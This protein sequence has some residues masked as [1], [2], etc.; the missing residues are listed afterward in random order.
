MLTNNHTYT[1][2]VVDDNDIDR[3]RTILYLRTIP[4]LKLTGE[5]RSAEEALASPVLSSVDVL[6]L[7]VDMPGLSGLELRRQ[8]GKNQVCIF[9]TSYA[10]HALE[11]FELAALDYLVKPVDQQRFAD[12]MERL[13]EY[14]NAGRLASL[15]SLQT[16]Q[17]TI[18]LKD[19][20]EQIQIRMDEI[21]YLEALKDYTRVVTAGK[22]FCVLHLLGSLLEDP[23]F[24]GFIRIHRSYAVPIQ[25]I[26]AL[27]PREVKLDSVT[28]PLGR[29]FK[30]AVAQALNPHQT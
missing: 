13:Q 22:K 24:A 1:S 5:F 7:D 19:G 25:R 16:G 27:T 29:T 15:Y 28:L 30:A 4:F 14:L 18:S 8:L 6:F 23:A 11:G 2:I 20:H 17:K 21:I 10:D 3:L 26:S 9:I 12:S